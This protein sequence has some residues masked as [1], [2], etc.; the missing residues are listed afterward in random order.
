MAGFVVVHVEAVGAVEL[1]AAV[2]VGLDAEVIVGVGHP[3]GVVAVALHDVVLLV[4]HSPDVALIVPDVIVVIVAVCSVR[5]G[6]AV[7]SQYPLVHIW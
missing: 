4:K 7:I 3:V 2:F 1:L 6:I 5:H